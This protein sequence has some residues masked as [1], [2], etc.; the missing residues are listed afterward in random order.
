MEDEKEYISNNVND[1][2]EE[3]TLE[4]LKKLEAELSKVKSELDEKSI[5]CLEQKHKLDDFTRENE[6]LKSEKIELQEM[7]AF[8]EGEKN[9]KESD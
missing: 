9:P 3:E 8:Y 4:K 1:L 2:G 7:L 5:L 6:D